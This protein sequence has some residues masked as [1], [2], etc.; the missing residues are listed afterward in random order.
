MRAHQI[1]QTHAHAPPPPFPLSTL[2]QSAQLCGFEAG[3][4]A[5]VGRLCFHR[6]LHGGGIDEDWR[7]GPHP[8]PQHILAEW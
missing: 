2:Q 7:L 5:G 6:L 8:G 1:L 3:L 4:A